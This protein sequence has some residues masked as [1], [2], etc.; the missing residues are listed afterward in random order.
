MGFKVVSEA[1]WQEDRLKVSEAVK[2][3]CISEAGSPGVL[4][5]LFKSKLGFPESTIPRMAPCCL[6]QETAFIFLLESLTLPQN[7]LSYGTFQLSHMWW[8]G[9]AFRH[10]ARTDW[11]AC[12]KRV[13]RAGPHWSLS[14]ST[15]QC[16]CQTSYEC[17]RAV[18]SPLDVA[19]FAQY[20]I[21]K[22]HPCCCIYQQF[23]PFGC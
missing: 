3:Y 7:L 11:S 13:R 19:A 10:V 9:E 4:L 14:N 18:H 22:T 21:F 12:E 6:I 17:H 5:S 8:R 23:I 1:L 16:A 15:A 20:N 2:F